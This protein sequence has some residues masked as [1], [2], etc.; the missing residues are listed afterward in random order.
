MISC[1][2]LLMTLADTR[3]LLIDLMPFI[4]ALLIVMGLMMRLHK[5]RR[6]QGQRLTAREQLE[7]ASQQQAL[8]NDL[9]QVMVEVEQLAKRLGAQL[10]AKAVRLEQLIRQADAR[11]TALGG[12]DQRDAPAPSAFPS[13]DPPP[14]RAP[15]GIDAAQADA[16]SRSVCELADRGL[17]P[18]QIARELGEHVGKVELILALRKA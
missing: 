4:G 7:R 12:L 11:I 3:Q 10:D 6:Q 14:D 1:P 13:D 15:S 16:L 5:R 2:P 17:S 18:V 8:R 9:E